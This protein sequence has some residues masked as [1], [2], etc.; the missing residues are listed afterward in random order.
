MP[1]SHTHSLTH[2]LTREAPILTWGWEGELGIIHGQEREGVQNRLHNAD[3]GPIKLHTRLE[4]CFCEK[5]I[6]FEADEETVAT[7][8]NLTFE[9]GICNVRH[10]VACVVHL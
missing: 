9:I 8:P 10:V 7:R 4:F 3:S 6:R 5:R 2:S 1:K